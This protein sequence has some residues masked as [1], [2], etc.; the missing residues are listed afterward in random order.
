M[1]QG[2]RDLNDFVKYIA[3]KATNEL[4]GF[5]RSGKP[6]DGKNEL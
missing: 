3:S 4:N 1:L 2:G 6:K 5:D